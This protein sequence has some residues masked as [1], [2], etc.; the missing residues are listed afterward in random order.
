MSSDHGGHGGKGKSEIKLFV[1]LL[2]SS[3]T[4]YIVLIVWLYVLFY[5]PPDNFSLVH[6]DVTSKTKG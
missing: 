6:G 2:I 4:V 3:R 1:R 5:V